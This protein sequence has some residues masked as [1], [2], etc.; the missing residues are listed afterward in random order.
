MSHSRL[1]W[2]AFIAGCAVLVFTT[3]HWLLPIDLLGQGAW[4][5]AIALA[6]PVFVWMMSR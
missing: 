3:W 5:I 6:F 4:G 1:E 2:V